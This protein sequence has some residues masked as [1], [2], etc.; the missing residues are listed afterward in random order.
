[1][2][3][4]TSSLKLKI[5][6]I[7]KSAMPSIISIMIGMV[8]AI[9]ILF[10]ASPGNAIEG[11]KRLFMGPFYYGWRGFGNMLYFATPLMFT[12][13]SVAFAFKTG[14]FNIGAPGQFMIG[15]FTAILVA[16]KLEGII[17]SSILWLISVMAAALMGALWAG[18]VGLLKAWR[19]VNEV[20]T[21]I[22]MN[23]IAMYLI[24]FLI[25]EW[26]IYD[27]LRN[28]TIRVS[29]HIPSLGLDLIFPTSFVDGGFIFAIAM[30]IIMYYLL[31][32]TTFG[33]EL[34]AV[35]LNRQA[36]QYVGIN[37]KRNV[38]FSM[39]ISGALSGMGGAFS[40]LAGTGKAIA[41][42][43]QIMGEGF[44]GIAV[45]LLGMNNPI[46]VIFSSMFVAYMTL[47]GDAM[48]PL[49]YVPELI[50]M[51]VGIILY[52]SA[53]AALFANLKLRRK[54]QKIEN[55]AIE[56]VEAQE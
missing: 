46:G 33:Y 48:Q 38:V 28:E 54:K 10:I 17:P 44:N 37:E 43:H 7:F 21:S 25:K 24:M 14:M 41:V 51:M 42:Q 5:N 40:Y 2:K 29:T 27:S 22:M 1:M 16:A 3:N 49:G 12:G 39:M 32:K 55:E 11:I 20:I 15:A 35:G 30:A 19:N 50:D 56:E 6:K 53:L 36:A 31:N 23:Y 18:I 9:L 4:N 45:A 47:S 52:V 8:I 13:L 34:K 26:G